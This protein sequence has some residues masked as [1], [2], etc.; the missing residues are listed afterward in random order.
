MKI[1]E[2]TDRIR[3]DIYGTLECEHCGA[4]RKF[5]GYDDENYHKNVLPE[6]YCMKCGLNRKGDKIEVF[7]Q[8]Q[9]KQA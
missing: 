5:V 1:K 7:V 6:F 8:E 2:I 3:N 4:T 9:V